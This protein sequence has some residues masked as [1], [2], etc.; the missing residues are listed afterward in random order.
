MHRSYSPTDNRVFLMFGDLSRRYATTINRTGPF[1]QTQ[2]AKRY[3]H[4]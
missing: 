3:V 4:V 2:P 1:F